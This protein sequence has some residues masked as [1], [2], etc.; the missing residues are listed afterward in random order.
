[1]WSWNT[2][3]ALEDSHRSADC[4]SVSRSSQQSLFGEIAEEFTA[5]VRRGDQP[6]VEEYARRYPQLESLMRA[7][8]PIL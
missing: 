8:F 1:M 7:T 2:H 6:D 5:R 4:V 3:L